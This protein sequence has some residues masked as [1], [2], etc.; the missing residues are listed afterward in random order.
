MRVA[1]RP[2]LR[3]SDNPRPAASGRLGFRVR[4]R[5]TAIVAVAASAAA[6]LTGLVGT[7]TPAQA[8]N[9][10]P[11]VSGWMPYWAIDAA[12]SDVNSNFDVFTDGSLFWFNAA[13]PTSIT[14]KASTAALT[15]AIA[16]LKSRHVKA[17]LTVTDGMG[18]AVTGAMF[19]DPTQ[20]AAHVAALMFIVNTYGADG[21]DLD[22]EGIGSNATTSAQ[23]RVGYPALLAALAAQLHAEG[24]TLAVSLSAKLAEPGATFGQQAYDYVAIGRI[25]DQAKI[26]TYDQHYSG[27]GPGAIAGMAWADSVISFAASAITPSKVYIGIP[28][29]GYDWGTP[30]TRATGVTYQAAQNLMAQYGATRLWDP[31]DDA[32]YFSYT[33][34]SGVPHSVW[35]NDAQSL[36]ARLPLVG[37]YGLGGIS[38]WSLGAEDPGIW[39]VLQ[40]FTYGSNPFGFAD[41]VRSAPG[42]AQITGWAIDPNS[43][44][45]IAVAIYA[46]GHLM[47]SVSSGIFRPDVANEYGFFGTSHGFQV[48]IPLPPGV[49]RLCAFG[50]NVGA[51]NANTALGCGNATA[52]SGNP[53]GSLD[54]VA[55]VP[56]GLS[57]YGWDIDPD[58]ASSLAT[59]VYVD[60]H[61]ATILTANQG[62]SDVAAQHGA[63]GAAH[64]YSAVLKTTAGVHTVCTYAINVGFGNDNT[65][66]GCKSV[67]VLSGSPFGH[68][69]AVLP[70]GAMWGWAI[71]PD[72]S[73]SIAV[74]IYVDGKLAQ[75]VAANSPR[76]DVASVYG[77][78][79][80]A[81]GFAWI[82][83]LPAGK[84]TVCAY[85]I[86]SGPGANNSLGCKSVTSP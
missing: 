24:K 1:W 16:T 46:D 82:A 56:G 13:S 17:I 26:M 51:G 2:S 3:V 28:L 5:L 54:A 22:Y 49:H 19:A 7:A 25:V 11:V 83:A 8:A 75:E 72:T 53:F 6:G 38:F 12:T 21:L 41:S 74:D 34:A 52:L 23:D 68:L 63:Y 58:T 4:R 78:Y 44:N 14:A 39:P 67:T 73:A 66:L 18:A 57:L 64:G 77:A 69:E 86:N 61:L 79:G 36:Q 10:H 29:Y 30:G 33:D 84:H 60:G 71:D 80:V 59:H 42:G 48:T 35:Y 31:T 81:H 9:P 47:G 32:P 85:G 20:R 76:P 27:G 55:P 40:G 50:M 45:P 62:R 43:S 65:K 15:S 70:S 37:K